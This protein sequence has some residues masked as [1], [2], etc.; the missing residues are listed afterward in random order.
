M[1]HLKKIFESTK[2]SQKDE[3]EDIFM[4]LLDETYA[5]SDGN[6][7]SNCEV[8]DSNDIYILVSIYDHQEKI[9]INS[10]DEYDNFIDSNAMRQDRIGKLKKYL[11]RLDYYKFTWGMTIE[12]T[13]FYIKVYYRD[14]KLV[15]V[16][17][18]GGEF[19]NKRFDEVIAK[20]VFKELYQ[21]DY[22]GFRYNPS[23]SGYYGKRANYCL[24]FSDKISDDSKV[25]NDLRNIKQKYKSTSSIYG[26]V[27]EERSIFYKI[28]LIHDGRTINIEMK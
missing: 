23:G 25:I 21:L 26:E 17:A 9:I 2:E 19:G 1:K 7:Y 18:F 28:E 6:Y 13:G 12:D 8:D 15:L 24:Y 16:D 14:T 3:V 27:I 5:G 20:R 22:I 4:E 11:Q 10:I